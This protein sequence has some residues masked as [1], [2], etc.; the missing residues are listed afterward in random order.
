MFCRN[1]GNPVDPQSV[2]CGP[3]GSKLDAQLAAEQ[4]RSH[5]VEPGQKA[6][7]PSQSRESVVWVFQA[8]RKFS[9]LKIMPCYIVFFRDR[10]VL[11][12]LSPTLQKLEGQKVSHEIKEKGLGFFK[13]SAEMM[14]YW[15]KFSQRYNT[16]AV[17]EIL[18][19]D[20]SN[21]MIYQ[22]DILKVLFKGYSDDS[23][24]GDAGSGGSMGKLEFTLSRG[25]TIK[26]THNQS[27]DQ[28]VKEVLTN[29]YGD[30]LKFKR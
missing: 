24:S 25:E 8:Q 6:N 9:M 1:C 19:E 2:F 17:D 18:A 22:Q 14:R 7:S 28:D 26:F 23:G 10:I 12:H 3:C 16:M 29:L 11:A 15:S 21:V 20:P 5:L 4:Q 13:G 27:A 30:K